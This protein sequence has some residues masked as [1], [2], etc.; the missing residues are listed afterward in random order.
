MRYT[1]TGGNSVTSQYQIVA[2][3]SAATPDWVN[4]PT[5]TGGLDLNPSGGARRDATGSRI[6]L[7]AQDNWPA[8]GPYPSN[9]TPAIADVDYFRVTPDNCPTGADTTA[10]T[11]TATTA[12]AAPNGANGWFTS[13]VNVT[14]AGTDNTGG[15]GIDKTEY[16]VDGG[17][18]ATYTAPIVVSTPG[19]HTVDYRS[20][21]KNGNVEATKTVTVKVDK[22]AP[23]TTAAL[24][25]ATPGAG[26]TYTGT[27]GL[28]L[29][30]ADPVSGVANTEYQVNTAT[31]FGALAAAKVTTAA[32]T[33][34]TYDPANKPSFTAPG[35]YSIDYRSTDA[36]GNVETAKT[37]TFTIAAVNTDHSAP[38]TTG[39]LEPAAP[40][41]DRTYSVPVTVK[42]SA[43]DPA[44]AGPAAKNVDIEASGD[45][46]IPDT[47]ALNTGDSLTWKFGEAAVFPHDVWVIAP[48]GNAASATQ[49]T[50]GLKFPGDPPVSKTFTQA[51]TWTFLC[52]VH[53]VLSNGTYTGMTGTAVVSAAPSG[54]APSGVDFTEYRVKT[55][56]VQGDWVKT[57]NTGGANPFASQVTISAEGQHTV[58]Y[59]ST[60]KAGNVEATKTVS[61]GIDI[62]EPGTPV[63]Q[64]FADPTSGT[65]PLL[66]RFS[67]TGF[68]PDGSTLSWR[69]VF[70]DGAYNGRAVDRTY[71]KPGTYTATVTA[72]DEQG[73]TVSKDVTVTVT[74]AGVLPPTVTASA[75][76]TSGP[77]TLP[78]S[79]TATG[80]DP[81]G[82]SGDLLYT[83][84]FG[85]G[86][87]SFA[88]NPTHTYMQPGT[89]T[90]KV[91]ASDATGATATKLL[92]ITV[93]APAGNVAPTVT[94][95]GLPLTGTTPLTV[96]LTAVGTDPNKDTL[97]YEWDFNDG[98]AKASG[99]AVEHT[100]TSAGTYKAK[101]TA[102]DPG[103][104]TSTSE[105]TIT[106]GNPP[107]N[108]A[109]SVT[110]TADPK[111]GTSPLTVQFSSHASDPEGKG[112]LIVWDFG[113]GQ[114]GGGDVVSHTYGQAG[115]YNAKVTV[116]DPGGLS[117]TTT[118]QI[119]VSAPAAAAAPAA[120]TKAPDAAPTA[121]AQDAWFGVSK[122]AKTTVATFT[123]T[124]LSVKVTATQAMTGSATITVSKKVAKALGLKKTTLAAGTVKF[125]G[126]GSR[127]VTLKP[128]AAVKRALKK[129]K[130]SVK[131][132][133]GVSLRATGKS[134]KKSTRTITLAS[135]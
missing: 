65:A 122:P 119:V 62:P 40:G 106:V 72:T 52:K 20:S 80:T 36:A 98:S 14:L 31:P 45:K 133:L 92:T 11:T 90:A 61:F 104:L 117:S 44:P 135:R 132:T 49:V 32:A 16:R 73:E 56:T 2:P 42:F 83:W 47:A 59:R 97:T 91:T 57:A 71:T 130:G 107:G 79:F 101:V 23:T 89:F 25:P 41:A 110:I 118:V 12:P 86:G 4:F 102:K 69:W 87:S 29:T 93:T 64:A 67:A 88:Q 9:G 24:T 114:F 128:S 43:N 74:A 50:S 85:D 113:D 51:G 28:T 94:A 105:V 70:A 116:T 38:V 124:G 7:I 53:S 100:Y 55:G 120:A 82:P 5:V 3:A 10:P 126:A 63:I 26:G 8:G 19:T 60:D 108:Q 77:A 121:P 48:G 95:D 18:F 96:K 37:V 134:A 111:A 131:V 68:D 115:T 103:G 112:L 30:A 123:K 127:S 81:D 13:D 21:D 39:T 35:S 1:R 58:D 54:D 129:A 125:A 33:Y 34:V 78:V 15:S 109:P 22:A 17:T 46:W 66:V 84:D 76:V 75:S 99:A 6:G 27:V